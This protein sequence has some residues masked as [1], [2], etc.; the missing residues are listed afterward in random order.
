MKKYF[1]QSV[2]FFATI[3]L[4]FSCQENSKEIKLS[5]SYI[6]EWNLAL[7]EGIINDFYSPPVASRMH[8][9]PNVAT[10]MVLK[11]DVFFIKKT[12]EINLKNIKNKELVS[13]YVFYE[14]GKKII[15]SYNYLDDYLKKFDSSILKEGLNENEI[16]NAK[17][18]AIDI[19]TSILAWIK[20]DNYKQT[21]SDTKYKLIEKEGFWKP[22]YPDYFDALEPNWTKIRPFILDSSSQFSK[23][24][25][26]YPYDVKNKTSDF[27]K[28]LIEVK[29]QVNKTTENELAIS[30]FW[31]CNPLAPQHVSHLTYAQKK[32][33]PGGH[34][35][36]IGRKISV[37]K[38]DDFQQA[39]KMYALLTS[40]I[41]DGFIAC[42]H[43]KY[44]HNYIRPIS[45]IQ[46]KESTTWNS[47][48]LTPNFPEYPSGHSVISGTA[49]TIL[50]HLYGNNVN[51]IDD[52]EQNFGMPP[53]QFNSFYEAC[54]EAA[55]S[56]FYAGIHFKKAIIDGVQMGKE[57]GHHIISKTK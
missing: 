23:K 33:T 27:F 40:S 38:K 9:Y 18:N 32:L 6:H 34:W 30:K 53:R 20:K 47:L 45:A 44:L 55:L 7:Q 11:N 43:S 35:I 31:D 19:S 2:L 22:T 21:R 56:R 50:T 28:E 5:A 49:S 24:Y 46:E 16:S 1:F 39:A 10:Y 29:N 54:D 48:I 57:I 3:I 4:F 8:C 13:L 51:F 15:Y 26:P 36:S 12:P 41:A 14:V 17:K 42:W 52:S 25:K 37:M